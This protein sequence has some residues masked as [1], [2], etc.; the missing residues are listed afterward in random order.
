MNAGLK[1]SAVIG[2]SL[3]ELTALAVSGK[4]SIRDCL[5]LVAAR[6]DLIKT[7]WGPDKRSMLAIFSS[8]D[9]IEMACYNSDTRQVVTGESKAIADLECRLVRIAAY[10]MSES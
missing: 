7:E 9:R 6:A 10:Q 1:V 4:L 3:G 2:H 5:K 8:R